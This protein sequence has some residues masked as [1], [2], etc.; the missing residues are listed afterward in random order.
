MGRACIHPGDLLSIFTDGITET[1]GA[2][3][4]E[5]GEL[6]LLGALRQ[7]QAL[8]LPAVIGSLENTVK[9]FRASD[10]LQDD[11]TLVVAR[12]K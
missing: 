7:S 8:E 9:Q 10:Y 6:R 4:D 12:G 3:G 5:F 2:D 1:T 11:L